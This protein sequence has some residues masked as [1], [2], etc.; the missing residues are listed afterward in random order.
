MTGSSLL[1]FDWKISPGAM[2]RE[3][4]GRF[5]LL[6]LPALFFHSLL[7]SGGMNRFLSERWAVTAILRMSV[8]PAEGEGIAR[9]AA[10]LPGA[11]SASYKD[12][13]AAW[14][15]FVAAYPGLSGLRAAGGNPLPGYVEVRML[16]GRFTEAE[17]D[18]VEA[19]LRPLP[20]VER[21]LSGG[22]V[23]PRLML[24]RDVV[25]A[26]LWGVFALLCAVVFSVFFLQEKSRAS[27]LAPDFDFLRERGAP[28]RRIVVSRSWGAMLAGLFLAA[29]AAGVSGLFLRLAADPL[30]LLPRVIGP[31]EEL[32]SPRLLAYAALFPLAVGLLSGAASPLGWR[33]AQSRPK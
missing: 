24:I 13:E 31:P 9:K 32:L 10:G 20:Q 11:R 26:L 30:P 19:A 27:S 12:P 3:A 18:A 2:F 22:E 7:L 4:A 1:W 33:S 6:L 16:P 29:A 8:P 21:I 14:K 23:L 15:E 25:N 17:I 5:F 28:V